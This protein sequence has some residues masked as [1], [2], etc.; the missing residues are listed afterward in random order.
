MTDMHAAVDR[1]NALAS[2]LAALAAMSDAIKAM[3]THA[4]ELYMAEVASSGITIRAL[5]VTGADGNKVAALTISEAKLT[6]GVTDLAALTRWVVDKYPDE[7]SPVIKE[8]F[9][10]KLLGWATEDSGA[11]GDRAD[12]ELIPGLDLVP[13][14]GGLK[15]TA[16]NHAK[17]Q[18]RALLAT[19]P[20]TALAAAALGE[21]AAGSVEETEK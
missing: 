13:S 6:G 17:T 11:P 20:R 1:I 3:Y 2:E 12:G 18:A 10:R 8:P 5:D 4:R 21:V 9:L 19:M 14:G 7:V 15:V 16:T